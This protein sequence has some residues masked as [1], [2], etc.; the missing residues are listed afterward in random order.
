MSIE[1]NTIKCD[2]CGRERRMA[3]T[4]AVEFEDLPEGIRRT[5]DRLGI[6]EAERRYEG[7]AAQVKASE[8][9]W[10]TSVDEGDYCPDCW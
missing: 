8:L 5:Y 1:G 4:S 2:A 9:G 7:S 3:G 10:K 6:P